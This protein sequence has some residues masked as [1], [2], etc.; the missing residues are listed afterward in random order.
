MLAGMQRQ[1]REQRRA[2]RMA[3]QRD[4]R[5]AH[6]DDQLAEQPDADDVA[7]RR[8][9]PMAGSRLDSSL[10]LSMIGLTM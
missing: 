5:P 3:R 2:L 6:L 9:S 10:A 4:R 1:P 8:R 7:V